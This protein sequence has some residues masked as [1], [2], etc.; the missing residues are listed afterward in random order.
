MVTFSCCK[1]A[2][3]SAPHISLYLI[4]AAALWRPSPTSCHWWAGS[5]ILG[6]LVQPSI[7]LPWSSLE[8]HI[9]C[10]T[11]TLLAVLRGIS[12]RVTALLCYRGSSRGG[13]FLPPERVPTPRSLSKFPAPQRPQFPSFICGQFSECFAATNFFS[14]LRRNTNWNG[15]H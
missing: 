8:P 9:L 12:N 10:P 14:P 11:S 6:L 1:P 5:N 4:S 15:K 7:P 13:S 3:P 2:T